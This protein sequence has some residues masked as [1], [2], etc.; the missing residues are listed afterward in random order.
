MNKSIVLALAAA[1]S[2]PLAP[3]RGQS[4]LGRTSRRGA[5][6]SGGLRKRQTCWPRQRWPT[7]WTP[8][9]PSWP[10]SRNSSVRPPRSNS[11]RNSLS[12]GRTFQVGPMCA[13]ASSIANSS[14]SRSKRP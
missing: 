14:P 7:S 1:A 11:R 5:N 12:G 6:G 3:R 4:W 8:R 9:T 10:R 2:L 13:T